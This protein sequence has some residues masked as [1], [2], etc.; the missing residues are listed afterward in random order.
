MKKGIAAFLG[1][2][3][4]LSFCL[5]AAVP[6][7]E[8]SL[9]PY[10]KDPGGGVFANSMSTP[11]EGDPSSSEGAVVKR[12]WIAALET[13]S[14]NIGVWVMDRYILNRPYARISW[15]TWKNN[16]KNGWIWCPDTF[17][18]SFFGH[19]YHGSQYFNAARSLGMNF[20]ESLPYSLLGYVMWG[21]FME[22][23]QPSKN[24]LLNTG[25]GGASFGEVEYRLSSQVLD[26]TATGGER[27]WREILAFV[28]DPIRGFNRL[29]YGDA[30]R[31]SSTNRETHEPLQGTASLGGS[32]ISTTGGLSGMKFSPGLSYDI[33]YGAGSSEIY[34][35]RPYDLF[36]LNG[37]VRYGQKQVNSPAQVLFSISTYGLLWGKELGSSGSSQSVIG[38]FQN[39]DYF[40]SETIHMGGMS[41]SG[42]LVSL[43]PLGGDFEL[44]TSLQLGFVPIGGVKNPYVRVEDRDYNYDWGGMG[45]AEAWLRHPK[46]GTLAVRF[47]R[48]QLYSI[49]GAAPAEADEGHDFWTY[50]KAAYTLPLAQNL[51]LRVEYGWYDLH[52]GFNGHL[53]V[54]AKLSR[55]GAALDMRF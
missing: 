14:I 48:F 50:I 54:V 5:T 9:S 1:L 26:D 51:G 33:T 12:P 47:G 35:K 29:I 46:F 20:W 53:P 10:A 19:P 21:Y 44:T 52:Q 42:G 32:L 8:F 13:F 30:T 55:V 11:P 6:D 49:N 40:N 16:L 38:L 39:Y 36:F 34:S 43:F 23:D 15:T 28:I 37:E 31:S 41:F 27:A 24:D 22:N 3:F 18:T 25:L 4:A 17:G 7:R 2:F 45:K